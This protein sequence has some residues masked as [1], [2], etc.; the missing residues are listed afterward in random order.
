M[1]VTREPPATLDSDA[2]VI[3]EARDRQRRRR[4][5]LA[6]ALAGAGIA[7]A[8]LAVGFGA[9]TGGRNGG[10]ANDPMRLTFVR[11]R[12]Y[13][14]GRPF[15]LAVSPAVNAGSV[16]FVLASP[17]AGGGVY[18]RQGLP[19]LAYAPVGPSPLSGRRGGIEYVLT[20]PGVAAVR[21]RGLG[22]FRAS[23]LPELP[24]GYKVAV[25]S[26]PPD[27]RDA[28]IF[29]SGGEPPSRTFTALDGAG[30]VIAAT[31][32]NRASLAPV[33][34]WQPPAP[35]PARRSCAIASSLPGLNFLWG[36]VATRIP[37]QPDVTD[38]AYFSCL[39]A[40]YSLRGGSQLEVAVLL[41]P[42]TPGTPPAPLWNATP[43]R[44]HPGV[45]RIR[46]VRARFA[47]VDPGSISLHIRQLARRFGSAF[48]RRQRPFVVRLAQP[49]W[50]ELAPAAVAR[51]VGNA[52]LLVRGGNDEAERLAVLDTLRITRIALATRRR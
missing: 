20:A 9:A 13:L 18:P 2:G 19:L 23:P 12:P 46:A 36:Q 21:V 34:L 30:H 52:W 5:R 3:E 31:A 15:P 35:A 1:T 26:W 42:R 49:Q 45:V 47:L 51:R 44:G 14:G 39:Y 40:A 24:P 37:D 7:V 50:Y 32:H 33:R 28:T 27:A 29:R 11:G 25:F 6:A 22:T 8:A 41:N 38:G 48:A 17:D 4:V 43:L 10:A 16:G